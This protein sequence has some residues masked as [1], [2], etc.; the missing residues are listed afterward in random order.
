MT[1]GCHRLSPGETMT[2]IV[3]PRSTR[4]RNDGRRERCSRPLC[5]S[6]HTI[7]TPRSPSPVREKSEATTPGV[8]TRSRSLRTQQRARRPTDTTPNVPNHRSS[9]TGCG[10]GVPAT[11]H[12]CSTHELTTPEQTPGTWL[13]QQTR[14]ACRRC[15]LERR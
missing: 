15:S 6:Q 9:R 5:S 1:N 4:H 11:N 2:N 3:F 12:R 14:K 10:A 7:G 8:P 13:W